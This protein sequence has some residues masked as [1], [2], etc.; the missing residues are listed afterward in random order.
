MPRP[1]H[2]EIPIDDA[3]RAEKFYGD[4]FGWTFN[5]FEG[6]PAYYGL[7][8]TGK[9]DVGID[10]ALYQR[11]DRT[12]TVLTMNVESIEDAIKKVEAAGGKVTQQKDSIPGVG[13]IATAVDTEGNEFGLFSNDENAPPPS[14]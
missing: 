2:F 9:E 5:R 3:D 7:A 14:R 13:W 12:Q 6:A 11:G 10:G 1:S 8:A 4:V